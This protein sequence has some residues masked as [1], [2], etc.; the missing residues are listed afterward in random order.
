MFFSVELLNIETFALRIL[1]HT[2]PVILGLSRI[3]L[4]R[5]FIFDIIGGFILGSIEAIILLRIP[6]KFF[7]QIIRY[8][9]IVFEKW[10]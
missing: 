6:E 3:A 8:V 7:F 4:G 9:P 5:H 1:V 10:H 2:F